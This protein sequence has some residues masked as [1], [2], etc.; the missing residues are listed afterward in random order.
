MGVPPIP[1]RQRAGS[2]SDEEIS[3]VRKEVRVGKTWNSKDI[4][5]VWKNNTIRVAIQS[6]ESV[7]QILC[8]IWVAFT[9]LNIG[10]DLLNQPFNLIPLEYSNTSESS[11]YAL[12]SKDINYESVHDFAPY[13]IVI[14]Q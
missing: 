6:D 2:K 10:D 11:T 8:K 9:N 1:A 4:F 3:R 12:S 14:C 13:D 5:L 7:Q